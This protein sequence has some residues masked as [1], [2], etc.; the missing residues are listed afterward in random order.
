[1]D[2]VAALVDWSKPECEAA[3]KSVPP[4]FYDLARRY[5][6]SVANRTLEK[7]PIENAEQ[8]AALSTTMG[9]A[10]TGLTLL[11]WYLLYTDERVER[12]ATDWE[13]G[14]LFALC[15]V[16]R[17]FHQDEKTL[18]VNAYGNPRQEGVEDRL[19]ALHAAHEFTLIATTHGYIAPRVRVWAEAV[20][21][22]YLHFPLSSEAGLIG[23]L[24]GHYY[25]L[26]DKL[27]PYAVCVPSSDANAMRLANLAVGKR[28]PVIDAPVG[29]RPQSEKPPVPQAALFEAEPA[30]VVSETK[31]FPFSSLMKNAGTEAL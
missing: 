18:L 26:L 3:L 11:R 29:M 25:T 12:A 23:N 15:A 6:E 28:V 7:Y 27:Q 9:S 5:V 22:A 21:V 1:M 20:G 17:E 31:A 10:L 30:P 24:P 8:R 2:R 16:M 4:R 13:V 19:A 14:G